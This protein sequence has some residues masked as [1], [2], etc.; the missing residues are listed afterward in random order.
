MKRRSFSLVLVAAFA[1]S[2]IASAQPSPQP[3]TVEADHVALRKLKADALAAINAQNFNRVRQL[4]HDPFMVTVVTQ[5]SFN[6]FDRLVGFYKSLYTTDRPD[7]PR[8]KKVSIAAEADELS[9]IYTGTFAVTRGSTV[10]RYELADGRGF[11][12]NGRWTGVSIK[13]G[14]EWKMLAVHTGTNFLDNPVLHQYEK[15]V[16]WVGGGALVAGL[17]IGFLL[18][19]L[20]GR[21]VKPQGAAE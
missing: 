1:M 10:E 9:Q 5:D 11:D 2:G 6:D 7:R 21:R 20:L 18:G 19:R 3:V 12:L 14:D 13:D 8:M 15:A 16:K 17:L 4:T